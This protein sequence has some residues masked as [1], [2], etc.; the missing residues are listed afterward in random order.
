MNESIPTKV[1]EL[2]NRPYSVIIVR[3]ESTEGEP[4]YF[5]Q[6]PEFEG[7]FGQGKTVSEADENLYAA[8]VD[9]IHSLLEDGLPVPGPSL[10]STSDKLTSTVTLSYH[11]RDAINVQPTAQSPDSANQTLRLYEGV[12]RT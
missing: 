1:S 7:C 2:A 11:Q 12:I 9:Y 10:T 4:V 6:S 3:E 5:A 8:R